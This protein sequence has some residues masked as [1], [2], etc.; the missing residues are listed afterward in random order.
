MG[1]IIDFVHTNCGEEHAHKV[2]RVHFDRGA[3]D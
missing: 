2:V 3:C 1:G